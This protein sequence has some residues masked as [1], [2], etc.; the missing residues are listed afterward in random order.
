MVEGALSEQLARLSSFQEQFGA[1][2]RDL[3]IEAPA[4]ALGSLESA[5][6][7]APAEYKAYL[8]ESVNCYANGLYR[9]SILM[10]WSATIGHLHYVVQSKQGGIKAFESANVARFGSSAGYRKI[11]KVDDLLYLKESQ[12]IILGE[13]AGLYNRNARTLLEERLRL[14]NL[15]GHPT[16]YVPG[17]E[18]TV[19]F[20]E[21]LLLNILSGAM[22][23]WP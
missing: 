21:S 15:C 11:K 8:V 19:I 10:V 7:S 16:G 12:V 14:R 22:L 23:N 6:D 13:D 17:R 2:A 5:V 18:E 4:A 1:A 20:V 3:E 9:A